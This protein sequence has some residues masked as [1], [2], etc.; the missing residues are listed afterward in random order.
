GRDPVRAGKEAEEIVEGVVLQVDHDE[1]VDR[2][3]AGLDLRT[4]A[5]GRP[6]HHADEQPDGETPRGPHPQRSSAHPTIALPR[7]SSAGFT[8]GVRRTTVT[9]TAKPPV[10]GAS[11]ATLPMLTPPAVIRPTVPGASPG[12]IDSRHGHAESRCH[13]RLAPNVRTL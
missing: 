10:P 3:R 9:R 12:R 8:P 6:E 13:R 2:R 1:V 5:W 7:M 11:I 4:G